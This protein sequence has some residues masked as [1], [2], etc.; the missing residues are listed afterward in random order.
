[1]RIGAI[2]ARGSCTALKWMALVGVVLAVGTG[3]ALAQTIT[4]AWYNVTGTGV[5]QVTVKMSA[6]VQAS[7]AGDI[8]EDFQLGT[9]AGTAGG[10]STS[11]GDEFTVTFGT[12]TIAGTPTLTYTPSTTASDPVIEDSGGRDVGVL[13]ATVMPAVPDFGIIPNQSGYV[14]LDFTFSLPPTMGGVGTV[15]STIPAFGATAPGT[16][17]PGEL[18]D[19]LALTGTTIT[20]KPVAAGRFRVIVTATDDAAADLTTAGSNHVGTAE[21]FIDVSA[22]PALMVTVSAAPMTIAEGGTSTIT[23]TANRMVAASDGTVTVNLAVVGLASLSANSIAIAAGT[24]SGSVT[25]TSTPDAD[26]V[27]HTV[28]VTATGSGITTSQNVMITVTDP[29]PAAIL[30]VMVDAAPTTIAEGGTST[31]TATANRMVMT[32]DGVVT[33]QLRVVGQA[34]LSAQSITIPAGMDSGSVTLTSTADADYVDDTVT[35]TATGTAVAANH[36]NIVITVT[37]PEPAAALTVTVS[38]APRTIAEGGTSTIT[39]MAN[40]MVMASDGTVTVNLSVVGDATLDANSITIAA[41]AESGTATL[42]S[43]HD[44]DYMDD[45]VTVTASGT[46]ITGNL[47]VEITVSDD[48]S[49]PSTTLGQITA[50][51]VDGSTEK[52][53]G[54]TKRQHV[55]EGV[56]T[57]ATITVRW[58]HAQLRELWS[59]V[60]EGSKPPDV[61]VTLQMMPVPSAESWLSEAENEAGHDDVT[62]GTAAMVVV[63]KKPKSVTSVGYEEGTGS[64]SIHFGQDPDAENEAFKLVTDASGFAADSL[65]ESKV[66]VI[67]DDDPQN[68][69]LKRDGSGVI[70]EGRSGVKFDVTADPPRE[71]LV[72]EVRFDLEDVTG[73]TVASRD[74]YI[75]KSIGTIPTGTGSAAK[76]T[77]TLTLDNNDGNREDDQ[78]ALHAEVV[79]Y[80]LD[81]GAYRGIDDPDPVTITVVDVHKLPPLTVSPSMG[82]LKEGEELELTLTIN[83]NPPDTIVI[84]GETREYTS[85]PVDVMLTGSPD[86]VVQISPRP[87]KFPKHS[88][89]ASDGWTQEMKVMV[90]AMTNDTIDGDR[91]VMITAEGAG[92]MAA[93]GMGKRSYDDQAVSLTVTD[94]TRKLVWAKT[95]DEVEAAVMAA[96]KAGMG[97]DM[98]F[99]AGEMIELEGNDLFG[100]AEGVSVGYTAMVEGD[101]VSESVSGGMVTITADSMGMAKVTITARA[102]RPS[103]AVM[104]NDQTDP[105][106]ASITIALEVGLVALSIELSGPEDMNL[107][108]GG[109]GGMVTATANRAVT[110][111][112]VVNLMRNRAM[113]SADDADFTAEP[114]TIMAGQM[115][116]ST[117]VMAVEDNMMENDGNMAEELVLYGMAADNA[118]EVTGHVKFYLWD[119]AVPALPVI[120]Q[121][122]LAALMAVGGYRRYRRR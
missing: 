22:P 31:I 7:G 113:S 111:D 58:S 120:A 19:G 14:G 73:Q 104:I 61:P 79:V 66:H 77:V 64:T 93:N 18:P 44:D 47:E 118:G 97:D 3:Q 43:T 57:K 75:D 41:G 11:A 62:I 16:H 25:L 63:P 105:R 101:A 85:E 96:K 65:K 102:S 8:F 15:T 34:T 56:L 80:A 103:G 5:S 28:T 95:L 117:M 70:Y 74:N 53:V 110:E 81:T 82:T 98:M 6:A 67:E 52:D 17:T 36:P 48:D 112:T 27:D 4:G 23:A 83:R 37:D 89:K 122:L 84:D 13:R 86:G 76:D 59:G 9:T 94:D 92:T 40:R 45:T 90:E 50:I 87:V 20:G 60:A 49:A 33:V 69:V 1:M 108:E 54:G 10:P 51:S 116:G 88:G 99:T 68:I 115:K 21:F 46:G 91:S 38:A 55:T 2:F 109:M 119:A 12:A 24:Q 42:T 72:L 114:I 107:V 71:D 26:Y 78:L 39:A 100:S 106:E 32:S 30:S 29:P 35:V 121:L